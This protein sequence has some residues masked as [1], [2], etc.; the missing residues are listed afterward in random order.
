MY[1][2]YLIKDRFSN[3][4]SNLRILATVQLL[5]VVEDVVVGG[6]ETGLHTVSHNLTGSWR[7]LQFLNLTSVRRQTEIKKQNKW[8]ME[9]YYLYIPMLALLRLYFLYLHTEKGDAGQEVNSR[10]EVL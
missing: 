4:V 3:R 7:T 9:A 1:F 5:T 2:Q 8:L 6:V 10:F